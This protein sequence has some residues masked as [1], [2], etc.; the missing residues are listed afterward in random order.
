MRLHNSKLN[1]ICIINVIVC[2]YSLLIRF[3]S[4]HNENNPFCQA[5]RSFAFSLHLIVSS[6]RP[7]SLGRPIFHCPCSIS[8]K[9]FR[10]SSYLSILLAL[11]T[12]R[13]IDVG[14][15]FIDV[16]GHT[17]SIH[18]VDHYTFLYYPNHIPFIFRSYCRALPRLRPRMVSKRSSQIPPLT[19]RLGTLK[20]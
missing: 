13:Y 9:T 6:F 10:F 12:L 20:M 7:R 16:M 14:I 15:Q 19:R 5:T 18:A 3:R 11:T 2:H 8:T 4:L 17:T 1:S